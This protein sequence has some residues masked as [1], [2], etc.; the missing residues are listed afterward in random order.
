MT[1]SDRVD[2]ILQQMSSALNSNENF[3]MVD[4]FQ[5]LFTQVCAPP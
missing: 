2:C 3:E 4:S 1:G 5:L